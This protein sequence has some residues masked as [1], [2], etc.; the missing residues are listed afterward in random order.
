MFL[1]SDWRPVIVPR[2]EGCLA[3][4]AE[5]CLYRGRVVEKTRLLKHFDE[6]FYFNKVQFV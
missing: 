3:S 1:L 2:L 5:I 4:G 6:Q